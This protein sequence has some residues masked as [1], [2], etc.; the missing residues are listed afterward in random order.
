MTMLPWYGRGIRYAQRS[1]AVRRELGDVWGQG[2]SLNFTGVVRYAASDFAAAQEA[3]DEAARLLRRTGDQWEVNT[4]NWN[5]AL[6][7]LRVGDLRACVRT[8]EETFASAQAIGDQ[9]A[10]GIALS[11]W[12][13]ATEGRVPAELVRDLLDQGSGDAQTTAELH[14]AD[15]LVHRAQGNIE[16]ALGCVEQGIGVIR[17]AGLRQEYIAPLFAWHATIAREFALSTPPYAP[18]LLRKRLTTARAAARRAV[19]WSRFYRNNEPHARRELALIVALRGRDR[20][21]RRELSRS[22]SAA[23]RI[24]ARYEQALTELARAELDAAITGTSFEFEVATGAVR[25]FDP[26][27]AAPPGGSSASSISVFDRFTTL[28]KVGRDIASATTETSLE[29]AIRSST[30]GLL[31]AER[32]HLVPA[33]ALYDSTLTTRSGDRNVH[34]LSRTLLLDAVE[35]G[36]PKTALDEPAGASDSLVLSGV[37]SAMAVPIFVGGEPRL[38]VYATHG[39]LGQLF[40]D[41]EAQLAEFIA[42]LAGAAFEHLLGN[43][44]RFRSLV[45]SSSDVVSLVNAEGLITYQSAAV[46][47]VFGLSPTGLAGTPFAD[48]VHPDDAARVEQLLADA[49]ADRDNTTFE[50]RMQHADGTSRFVES[51]ITNLLDEPTVGALVV[52]TRDITERT[53]AVHQLHIAEER[54]RIA[55]DLHDVVI[56]R[57]FAVG[58]QLDGLSGAM[59]GEQAHITI[60]AAD[61]LRDTIRDIRT[62]IFTLRSDDLEPSLTDRLQTVVGRVEQILGFT[63][64]V[65]LDDDLDERVPEALHWHVIATTNEAMSNAARHAR[66]TTVQLTVSVRD[67]ELVVCI[68]DNGR[69]LPAE[70]QESGLLNLRRRAE[71]AGGTMT[72]LPGPD[73]TGLV[74]TWTVPLGPD[75][76]TRG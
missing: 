38:L 39:Q 16:L 17:S 61:E 54:E 29:Q 3:C 46:Q 19:R 55:R 6:I 9:T 52:N 34:G 24:G 71:M 15:A 59:A 62:A 67:D 8:C 10:A 7:L 41:A 21:A 48:W 57:L 31:R 18:Q 4:A 44:T 33:A 74:L 73:G 12:A 51:T 2:Q 36:R 11:I 53:E 22:R 20:Q 26:V 63:P 32:C 35:A 43:E 49:A 58:L 64:E 5:R 69:G 1:L 65:H 14:L 23:E 42:T 28:L 66:A 68:A 60:A 25:A 56:Q 27:V 50:C 30:M 75:Q 13:R 70:R 76:P 45:Q 72:T 37:R 40:G 47:R